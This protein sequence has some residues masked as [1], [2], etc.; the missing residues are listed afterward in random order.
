MSFP[1][2]PADHF[3]NHRDDEHTDFARL[4]ASGLVRDKRGNVIHP[5]APRTDFS[6]LD[7]DR[8][9]QAYCAWRAMNPSADQEAGWVANKAAKIINRLTAKAMS[10][11]RAADIIGQGCDGWESR[12]SMW[13]RGLSVP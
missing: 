3:Q 13:W 9:F 10:P 7:R 12:N 11:K 1:P 8:L 2:V 6:A 4:K 5:D